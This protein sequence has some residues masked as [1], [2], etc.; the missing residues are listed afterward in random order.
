[1][2]GMTETVNEEITRMTQE[3]KEGWDIDTVLT[4]RIITEGK[5]AIDMIKTMMENI[6]AS[7]VDMKVQ[8]VHLV[9][10]TSV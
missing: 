4:E 10:D 5:H 9:C 6:E 1:M 7:E 3:V 2:K 8:G